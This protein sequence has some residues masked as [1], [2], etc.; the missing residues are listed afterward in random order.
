MCFKFGRAG[1]GIA[2][3]SLRLLATILFFARKNKKWELS[4][5]SRTLRNAFKMLRILLVYTLCLNT[6]KD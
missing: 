3:C 1:V 5:A 2:V 4:G 6:K